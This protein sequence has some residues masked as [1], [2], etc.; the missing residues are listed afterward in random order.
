MPPVPTCV[1]GILL[2]SKAS[3]KISPQGGTFRSAG[4]KPRDKEKKYQNPERSEWVA[5]F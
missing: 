1:P 2:A 3:G 4:R 5:D